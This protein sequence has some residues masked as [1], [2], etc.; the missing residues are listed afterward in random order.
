MQ[1]NFVKE[2]ASTLQWRSSESTKLICHPSARAAWRCWRDL[3]R[4]FELVGNLPPALVALLQSVEPIHVRRSTTNQAKGSFE[5]F[6]GFASVALVMNANL[7]RALF[8]I[9]EMPSPEVVANIAEA[10]SLKSLMYSLDRQDGLHS[11]YKAVGNHFD[12]PKVRKLFEVGA[13]SLSK[14]A[15]FAN[16]GRSQIREKRTGSMETDLTILQAILKE[17]AQDD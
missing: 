16:V 14:L 6:G 9:H 10:S 12:K 1:D 15:K 17:A 13:L 8:C 11:L 4:Q 5:F 3:D 7:D 2:Y